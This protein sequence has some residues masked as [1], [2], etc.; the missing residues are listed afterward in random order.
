VLPIGDC[1]AH[2]ESGPPQVKL[3]NDKRISFVMSY[4]EYSE[5]F[6]G[7]MNVG[8]IAFP[9]RVSPKSFNNSYMFKK[10]GTL[11][12][13]SFLKHNGCNKLSG[14]VYSNY[15]CNDFKSNPPQGGV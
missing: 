5:I 10:G 11:S 13:E 15:K 7:L 4:D 14:V 3:V 6:K 2:L 8:R 9:I 12:T 1:H